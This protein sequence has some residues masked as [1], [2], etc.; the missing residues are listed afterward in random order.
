M[1]HTNA[2]AIHKPLAASFRTVVPYSVSSP[3]SART[4]VLM[5]RPIEWTL[6]KSLREKPPDA[7]DAAISGH[8]RPLP[9]DGGTH[10]ACSTSS[11][12]CAWAWRR[13]A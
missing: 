13:T 11:R 3:P 8:I 7:T 12:P 2:G 4:G 6:H 1:N 10:R 5:W 9:Y